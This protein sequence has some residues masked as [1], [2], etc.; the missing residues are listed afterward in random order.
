MEALKAGGF[1]PAISPRVA[2]VIFTDV[3]IGSHGDEMQKLHKTRKKIIMVVPHA[4]MPNFFGDFEG[5]KPLDCATVQFVPASG[6]VDVMRAW[7]Y[8]L[9][10]EVIGW[11]L[12]PL[13]PFI[14]RFET[15]KVLFA[16]IHPNADNNMSREEKQINAAT[17]KKLLALVDSGDIRLTVRYL[18]GLENN[19]L[20]NY[21]GVRYVQGKPD[22]TTKEIDSADIV[23]SKKTMQYLAVARGVPVAGMGESIPPPMGSV[24][25]NNYS[26]VRSWEKYKEIMRFPLDILDYDDTMG[27]FKMISNGNDLVDSWR[28]RMIGEPFSPSD[29]VEKVKRH[30]R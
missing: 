6:H 10:V 9:P 8:S 23:V 7:G 27:L 1:L 17:Y 12:C 24:E 5:Y 11:Y 13:V 16:P 25:R 18:R 20:W 14:K 15:R 22:Q 4:A 30:L 3:D 2:D 28:K 19:G 21:P 26:V 29:F